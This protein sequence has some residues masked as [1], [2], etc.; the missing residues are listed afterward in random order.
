TAAAA[1]DV[2]DS[3]INTSGVVS[4]TSLVSKGGEI[5]LTGAGAHVKV[6]GK[7]EASGKTGGGKIQIG[8]NLHG[9][10][11]TAHAAR[12]Q[13]AKDAVIAANATDSGDGGE[14]AV[15]STL[16]S[17]VEGLFQANGGA[18][19]GNGGTIETSS[20]G[21]INVTENFSADASAAHGTSGTWLL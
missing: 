16:V 1:S 5:I 11:S 14:I 4:A 12:G 7:V 8:G 2:V 19:S 15:W 17:T 21:I 6:A 18:N 3:V 20:E 9:A 10:G 13:I